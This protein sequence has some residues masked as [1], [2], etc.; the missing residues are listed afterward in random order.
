MRAQQYLME[1]KHFYFVARALSRQEKNN[2][3][4]PF[5]SSPIAA[6]IPDLTYTY[7]PFTANI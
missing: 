4:A 6:N 3:M 5:S 7:R 2:K 1:I